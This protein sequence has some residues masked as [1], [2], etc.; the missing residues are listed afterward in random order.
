MNIALIGMPG[1]GK[2]TIG[3]ALAEGL[4]L[5][6]VDID[7]EMEARHGKPLQTI[8]DEAGDGGFIELEEEAVLRLGDIRDA[9][10]STGGSIVY[11]QKAM[12]RLK[13][14]STIV[15]L[16]VALP[17]L[18]K[19]L[20]MEGRGVVRGQHL[21]LEQILEERL[22]LYKRYAHTEVMLEGIDTER[23]VARV[24]AVLPK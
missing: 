2:S 3:R 18:K 9:L 22:P 10:I 23:N 11:S 5:R 8:L 1:A 19:R 4:G 20:D 13:D 21:T 6:F 16:N 24:M 15:F 17:D 12:E 7:K 14:I